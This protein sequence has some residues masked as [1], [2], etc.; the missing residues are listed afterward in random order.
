MRCHVW[1]YRNK[2]PLFKEMVLMDTNELRHESL[3]MLQS[4]YV[5]AARLKQILPEEAQ[6]ERALLDKLVKRADL[7]RERITGLVL[8]AHIAKT[9]E[10]NNGLPRLKVVVVED[11]EETRSFLTEIIVKHCKHEVIAAAANGLEMVREVLIKHP[12]LVVF[13]I[14]LPGMDGLTAL[15]EISKE[16][17]IPA[18][19]ITGDQDFQ[20]IKRALEDN[21]LAYLL[22][23]VDTQQL[24]AAIQVAWARFNEFC[25]LKTEN[26]S[27]QQNL[28]DRKII[29]KA[30]G[31]LMQKNKWTENQAFRA[32]QRSAMD[33]RLTMVAIAQDILREPSLVQ[34]T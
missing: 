21:I 19:A 6:A 20:L 7:C 1:R 25:S 26:Q 18:V 23:P 13:D 4:V 28:Q 2:F 10:E 8:Q 11:D 34:N 17:A 31:V 14:H 29:E 12:D 5:L 30:K 3:D 27:L 24:A 15:H 9:V 16:L 32:L 22:K 33:R